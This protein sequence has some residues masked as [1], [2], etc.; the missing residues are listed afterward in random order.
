MQLKLWAAF[1]ES[2]GK[3]L[4]QSWHCIDTVTARVSFPGGTGFQTDLL[5]IQHNLWVELMNKQKAKMLL[6]NM[7]KKTNYETILSFCNR[8]EMFN[9]LFASNCKVVLSIHSFQILKPMAIK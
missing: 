8:K 9:F 7:N 3:G 5:L 4:N 6:H 2:I 1:P